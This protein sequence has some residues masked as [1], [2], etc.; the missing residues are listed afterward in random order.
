MAIG[1]S[2]IGQRIAWIVFDGQGEHLDGQF[3]SAAAVLVEELPAAQVIVKCLNIGS[4]RSLQEPHF[5]R[6]KC[7]FEGSHDVPRNFVADGEHVAHF[8]VKPLR[9]DLAAVGHVDK[10]GRNTEPS[11]CS[12]DTTFQQCVDLQITADRAG[13]CA[14]GCENAA[15]RHAKP[16]ASCGYGPDD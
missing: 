10:V 13:C 3:K 4:G 11:A 7:Q 8:P 12:A 5:A 14:P 16:T 9:P 2:G 1:D 15:P 6:R